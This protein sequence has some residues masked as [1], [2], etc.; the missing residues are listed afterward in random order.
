MEQLLAESFFQRFQVIANPKRF[1]TIRAKVMHPLG[2]VVPVA[3]GALEMG[4]KIHGG[5]FPDQ[6]FKSKARVEG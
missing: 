1:M 3:L 2:V 5:V 4:D 6:A